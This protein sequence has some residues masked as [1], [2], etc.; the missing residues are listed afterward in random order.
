MPPSYIRRTA[1]LL[2]LCCT[3]VLA[4]CGSATSSKKADGPL[5]IV[6]SFPV[7]SLDP[8]EEGF[9]MPEFGV[10]E[11][12][13]RLGK[14]GQIEPWAISALR[15]SNPTT[16][17]LQ[18]RPDVTFQNG[19]P[20]DADA[21]LA[22]MRRQL[23]KSAS[24][25]SVLDGARV[26]KSAAREITLTTRSP[27][28]AMPDY[29]SDESVFPVYDTE[30]VEQVGENFAALAGKGI[31][32]GPY[33]VKSLTGRAMVLERYAGYWQGRPPLPGVRVG[34]VPDAQARILAVRNGEAD[35]A[36]YPPTEAKR[37]L[38]GADDA[39]YRTPP[40]GR[41]SES[42]TVPLNIRRAP[43]DDVRVR[44]AFLLGIDYQA[45]ANDA[46]D[47][48]YDVARGMYPSFASFAVQ[49]QTTDPEAA[50]QLLDKAGW[51]PGDDGIR[52]KDGKPL[53]VR[54]L[55][56]PQQ[57][58]TRA[59]AIAMQSQLRAV[60]F[61][62]QVRQVE[63]ITATFKEPDDWDAGGTFS[64]T[65]GFYGQPEPFL[66]RY[67]VT[68]GSDNYAGISDPKLDGLVA[69]LVRTFGPEKRNSILAAIQRLVVEQQ[70]YLSVPTFKRFPVIAGPAYRT[71]QPSPSLNHV[72]F[73]TAPDG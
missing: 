66:R 33:A 45:I 56:Y 59:V 22:L 14:D 18:L 32:T 2:G 3:L 1:T 60:G 46:L 43:F 62:V 27:D 20:L 71:Y 54:Y 40:K 8:I 26:R 69:Q 25:R 28:A 64:G 10:A 7:G 30:A 31:Y 21:L 68:K 49:T 48:A 55:T 67:L 57:P 58:D 34:F 9:W 53:R 72:T 36:L 65:L 47:G 12:P 23:A 15:R 52:V 35:L 6:T 70:A 4:A 61:D 41:G 73:E 19:K 5:R 44:R 39:V 24:A 17:K 11:T 42:I 38:D 50:R 29:L 13:M 51:K 37:T 16:W 63:D